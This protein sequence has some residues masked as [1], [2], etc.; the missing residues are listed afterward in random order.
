[1]SNSK[2]IVAINKDGDARYFPDGFLRTGGVIC[3]KSAPADCGNPRVEI[4]PGPYLKT[5]AA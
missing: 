1:M 4:S 2:V 5:A 3:T